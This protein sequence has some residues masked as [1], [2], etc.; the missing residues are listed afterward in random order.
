[1]DIYNK[2]SKNNKIYIILCYAFCVI[3]LLSGCGTLSTDNKIKEQDVVTVYD[4]DDKEI[5]KFTSKKDVAYFSELIGNTAQN[6]AQNINTDN[7]PITLY[8]EIPDDAK[9]SFR[10]SFTH[11]R[12]TGKK[13]TVDF[14]VYENYPYI[15]LKGL[16]VIAPLTW[17]LSETDN[18]ILQNPT[19]YKNN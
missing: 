13:T 16:P 19:E 4:S 15:T 17:E 14:S 10:Y 8:K 1:M 9:I 18:K 2:M 3:L 11:T 7:F 12:Q 5:T 6:I